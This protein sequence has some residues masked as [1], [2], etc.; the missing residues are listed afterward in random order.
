[1]VAGGATIEYFD[2]PRPATPKATRITVK[3]DGRKRGEIISAPGGGYCY[4]PFAGG[5]ARGETF[6]TIEQVQQ[7]VEGDD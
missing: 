5:K 3:I 6:A 7:S 4:K 2:A 1:M